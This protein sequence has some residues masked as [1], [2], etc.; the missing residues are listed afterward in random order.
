ME[1]KE[2]NCDVDECRAEGRIYIIHIIHIGRKSGKMAEHLPTSRP[3]SRASRH[4]GQAINRQIKTESRAD[5]PT[6]A[7]I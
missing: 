5:A 2:K 1:E 6:P 3:V 7:S 4:S